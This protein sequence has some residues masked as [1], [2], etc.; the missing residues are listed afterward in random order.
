M[1][2]GRFHGPVVITDC[3]HGTIEPELAV[4]QAAGVSVRQEECR[5]SADVSSAANDAEVLIVQYATV[6]GPALDQL[7]NC[8]AI[9]RYGVGVETIDVH[10]ATERGIWVVN[11][12]DYCTDEVASHALAMLLDLVRGVTMLDRSVRAGSWDFR[13]ASQVQRLSSLTLG[14]VGHGRIGSALAAKAAALGFGVLAYDVVREVVKP[15]AGL[16]SLDD[17]LAGAD[18]VS[19][20]T[21]LTQETHH[22]VDAQFLSKMRSGGFLVNTAR[23]AIVDGS[24]LLEALEVGTLAGAGLDVLE[25]EPPDGEFVEL[26]HHPSVIA[27]PHSAWWSWE[28]FHV[29][30]TEVAREAL[31]VLKGETPRS[32]LNRPR[33]KPILTEAT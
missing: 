16:V 1:N 19:V 5:T 2:L 33:P 27:T 4:L 6:D 26:V 7:P 8:R 24:A 31:R 17:L 22:M 18:V 32:P 29:L 3:D 13:V 11:V 21:P 30:K 15:P 25:R 14:I 9:I 20:H 12:P 28:S 23:G 10:A